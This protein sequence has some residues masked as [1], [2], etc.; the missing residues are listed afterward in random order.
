MKDISKEIRHARPKLR[1]VSPLAYWIVMILGV[2]NLILGAA[3]FFAVDA[4]K[5]TTSL[6]IVNDILTFRF[7]GIMFFALGVFKLF[8]LFTNKWNFARSS[9]LIGVTLKA[10][11]AIALTI[12]TIVSPGTVFLSVIWLALALIQTVTYIFFMPPNIQPALKRPEGGV[13]R[14]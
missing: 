6:I 7:W 9:L 3:F 12:R 11:W 4:T 8:A 2:F 13:T 10:A 1:V 14:A 5:I